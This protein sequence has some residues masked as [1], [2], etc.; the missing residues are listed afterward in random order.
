MTD[1]SAYSYVLLR[2]VHDIL[3][4]EFLN[5]GVVLL[6]PSTGEI[7]YRMRDTIDRLKAVF[8]NI[9][10]SGFFSA[11]A[12]I[13][14]GLQMVESDRT[15]ASPL[16]DDADVLTVA[17]R[18]LPPDD[19]SLQWS[20]LGTGL[21]A[22]PEE[23]LNDIFENYVSRYDTHHRPLR[24]DQDIGHAFEQKLENRQLTQHFLEASFAGCLDN[25]VFHH[26]LRLAQWQVFQ[27][28]SFDLSDADSIRIKAREWLGH[29]TAVAAGGK[30]EPYKLHFIVGA[31]ANPILQDAY[32][33]ALAILR[34]APNHPAIFEENELEK[35]IAWIEDDVRA[36]S[37]NP[38]VTT[39]DI[40]TDYPPS[41]DPLREMTAG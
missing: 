36:H 30:A 17:Y 7:K 11:M 25:I 5:V 32:Q 31:P 29:L 39:P 27:P 6:V 4:E 18:A 38:E 10:S 20:Q 3:T 24:C 22:N 15:D 26:A 41:R 33:G 14:R 2:Y 1:K 9:D 19:S 40:A 37:A 28:L 23:T 8:P 21:T 13:R 34:E 35:L 16:P 12:A